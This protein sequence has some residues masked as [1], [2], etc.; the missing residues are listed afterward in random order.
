ML[1]F[2]NFPL[3]KTMLSRSNDQ[4][5]AVFLP[6]DSNRL[7]ENDELIVDFLI[8]FNQIS[9]FNSTHQKSIDAFKFKKK[10]NIST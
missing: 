8:V 4:M 3:I 1:F 6:I 9:L 7:I 2:E 10:N 5:E